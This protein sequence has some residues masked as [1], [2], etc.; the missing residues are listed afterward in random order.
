MNSIDSFDYA[1][2]LLLKVRHNSDKVDFDWAT[3]ER[4][5]D[6]LNS[7]LL[8]TGGLNARHV[9]RGEG[10]VKTGGTEGAGGKPDP[11]G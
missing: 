4:D 2:E 6:F 3:W 7:V 11:Q 1:V 8:N 5:V 9:G 10:G